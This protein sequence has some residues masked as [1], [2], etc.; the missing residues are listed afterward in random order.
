MAQS[1]K[2]SPTGGDFLLHKESN[3]YCLEGQAITSV[4]AIAAQNVI[5]QPVKLVTG[6]WTFVLALDEANAEGFVVQGPP[7]PAV[8]AGGTTPA[9]YTIVA[10][11]PAVCNEDKIPATDTAGTA[12]TAATLITAGN[13]LNPAIVFKKEPAKTSEQLT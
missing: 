9:Q 8:G 7:C 11:G 2:P 10:R 13:G 5:G 6:N 1:F 3:A 4:G 12:M